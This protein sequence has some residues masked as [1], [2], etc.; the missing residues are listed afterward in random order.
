[1]PH[2]DKIRIF[3]NYTARPK[4]PH[5]IHS[6]VWHQDAGLTGDGSASTAPVEERL[7]SYGIGKVVNCWTPLV[8]A[9]RENGAMKFIPR[10]Q[11]LGILGHEIGG[12]QPGMEDAPEATSGKYFTNVNSKDMVKI[13]QYAVDIECGPGDVVLFSNILVHCG[14]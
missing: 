5:A 12:V 11:K 1:M 6:V 3:P 7:D 4:T 8:K 9:N 14:G 10:S 13:G 2:A